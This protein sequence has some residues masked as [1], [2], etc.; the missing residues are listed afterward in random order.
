MPDA[1]LDDPVRIFAREFP[2][3][4]TGVRVWCTIGITFKSNSGHANDRTFGKPPFQIVIF[5]FGR[6]VPAKFRQMQLVLF[7][8]G[9]FPIRFK[10]SLIN[11][12]HQQTDSHFELAPYATVT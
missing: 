4:G 10:R 7:S 3:I 11:A 12:H 8:I 5:R 1:A 2:G 9:T 6:R